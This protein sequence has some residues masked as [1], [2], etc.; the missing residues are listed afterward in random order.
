MLN[1]F[2]SISFPKESVTISDE[3]ESSEED[4]DRELNNQRTK[5]RQS[6]RTYKQAIDDILKQ[7]K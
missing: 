5:L 7:V 1:K 6:F 4:S 2:N 3:A